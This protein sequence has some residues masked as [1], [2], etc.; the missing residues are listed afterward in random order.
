MPGFVYEGGGD[1]I[2]PS[3]KIGGHKDLHRAHRFRLQKIAGITP[4]INMYAQSVTLPSVGFDM[5]AGPGAASD[6]KFASKV[7]FDDITV[8]FYDVDGVYWQ[9]EKER[10]K[11]W[12]PDKG[13]ALAAAYKTDTVII[14]E[15]PD[16]PFYRWTLKNSWV[17]AISHSELAFEQ[18]EIKSVEL[19]ISYDW[20]TFD[21]T[22]NDIKASQKPNYAELQALFSMAGRVGNAVANAAANF[23]NQFRGI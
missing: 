5:E 15:T 3:H 17:S 4:K 9:I 13:L 18:N 2:H 21:S 8:S 19:T 23:A 10:E 14:L 11:I 6:Y 12:T 22:T 20:Y 7:S 16:E 1:S